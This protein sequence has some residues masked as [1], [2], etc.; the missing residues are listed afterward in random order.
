MKELAARPTRELAGSEI[1][2]LEADGN[3]CQDWTRVRVSPGF[4]YVQGSILHSTFSGDCILGEL[5]AQPARF[6]LDK[7][8]LT[9]PYGIRY[10]QISNS[11]FEG[12]VSIE[13]SSVDAAIVRNGCLVSNARL[14]GQ[15][16]STFGNGTR[17]PIGIEIGGREIRFFCDL[18]LELAEHVL[19]R[20]GVAEVHADYNATVDEYCSQVKSDFLLVD[21]GSRVLDC[22]LLRGSFLGRNSLIRGAREIDDSTIYST[23]ADPVFVGSGSIVRSSVIQEGVTVDSGALVL[24]SMLFEHS[25]ATEHAKV[26][27]TI[28][29]PNSGVSLGESTASF[30]GPFIGFHHQSLLIASYW[31]GGRGN[32]GY[33]ANVGSNHTTRMP[34]QECWPGEGMFF[35]LSTVVKYP[36]N[37]R[38]APYTIIAA[39][40]TTL[41]QK[42]TC[43]FSLINEPVAYYLEV[44]PGYNNLI[45]AWGLTENLY[46]LKR[47][48]G[49]FQARNK[50]KR[51]C[52]DL[53]LFRP[54]VLEFME[55]AIEA[56]SAVTT[57][58]KIYLP[59]DIPA[60]G[61]N[62][63]T[64]ENRVKGIAA[65][66]LFIELARLKDL[67]DEV[68]AGSHP[69]DGD[70]EA[71]A[72]KLLRYADLVPE[73]LAR[74]VSS[75]ERDIQRGAAIIDDYRDTHIPVDRDPFIL[76][77]RAEVET[78]LELTDRAIRLL[79][80]L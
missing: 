68:L 21:E 27:E 26:Q 16:G 77:T 69:S 75:R 50:A 38:Q 32:I 40:V 35:G 23:Q 13:N 15:P 10:S 33:G 71:T 59:D 25:F 28:V 66:K 67:R 39:G 53:K 46:S 24:K 7:G 29:G 57:P 12:G 9:R 6:S 14:F 8:S 56:L 34:D 2:A 51:N 4:S 60:I 72:A 55:A 5:T 64:E 65:Y 30:I 43:P 36:S 49:K 61:K 37:F 11:I 1:T 74:T 48:E 73:I 78:E 17:I 62:M 22:P 20:P 54:Q 58:K 19:D 47:N 44:P 3:R 18:S 41:P 79:Q 63:M 45:P 70:G 31:P 80:G 52:F 42:M 76:Q